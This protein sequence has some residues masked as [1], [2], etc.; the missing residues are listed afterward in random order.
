MQA[1]KVNVLGDYDTSRNIRESKV[2]LIRSAN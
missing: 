2:I 1:K